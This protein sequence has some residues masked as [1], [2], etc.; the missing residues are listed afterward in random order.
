MTIVPVEP[1]GYGTLSSAQLALPAR[2][3]RRIRPVFR[4]AAGRP[5]EVSYAPVAGV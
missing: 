3:S 1:G 2:P 5:G 4:F